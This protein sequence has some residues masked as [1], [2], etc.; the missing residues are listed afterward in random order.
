MADCD[1]QV[2]VR[3][4]LITFQDCDADQTYGP[5]SHELAGEDQP[6]YRLCEYSN[7]PLPG[8]YVR[9]TKGNN[10]ISLTV[11]R[12][13]AVPLALYQGCAS[14]DITIEHFNGMVITG[15]T[16]TS[17]GDET[18][19]GHEVTM[20]FTFKEVDELLPSVAA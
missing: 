17:T 7:E 6:Q 4:I 20:T 2:G 15:L 1:N 3:N 11:I 14:V 19:D 13:L 18:S 10:Q 5:F 12:N 16:G 8:G 9:R